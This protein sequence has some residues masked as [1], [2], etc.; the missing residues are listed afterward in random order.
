MAWKIEEL[1]IETLKL[2]EFLKEEVHYHKE[3][4][5]EWQHK[6][7]ILLEQ[8][9]ALAKNFSPRV[10]ISSPE[11]NVL[12]KIPFLSKRP[13]V[14]VGMPFMKQLI[15]LI[16]FLVEHVE[17]D[18]SK[19]GGQNGTNP[20]SSGFKNMLLHSILRSSSRYKKAKVEASQS[21]LEDS[22]PID[23]VPDS[24]GNL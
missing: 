16:E 3:T 20:N 17:V 15:E 23:F 7:Q 22:E 4:V 19:G 13:G 2:L 6:Q 8:I 18:A 12:S 10:D 24:Q 11:R 14:V 21:Q 9:L 1:Q 5:K